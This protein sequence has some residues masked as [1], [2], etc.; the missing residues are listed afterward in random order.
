MLSEGIIITVFPD[1]TLESVAAVRNAYANKIEPVNFHENALDVLAHQIA[2]ILMDKETVTPRR[3]H[4]YGAQSIPLPQT[5]KKEA[6]GRC[7]LFRQ[8]QPI[9]N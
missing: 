6:F 4:D 9:K 2:G 8:P 5:L 7:I 1:D 3:N